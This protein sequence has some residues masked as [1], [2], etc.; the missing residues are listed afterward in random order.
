MRTI[1]H[2]DELAFDNA[3]KAARAASDANVPKRETE[4]LRQVL[5]I[6]I[7]G[8]L[9]IE[10]FPERQLSQAIENAS[11]PLVRWILDICLELSGAM[12]KL[13]PHDAIPWVEFVGDWL[14]LHN[15]NTDSWH[16][17]MRTN[18]AAAQGAINSQVGNNPTTRTKPEPH[19]PS[20]PRGQRTVQRLAE[21]MN[22]A[23]RL[24]KE[25]DT[26]AAIELINDELSML[27]LTA[28]MAAEIQALA[29]LLCREL[30]TPFPLEKR[31]C[32]QRAFMVMCQRSSH[33]AVMMSLRC[34]GHARDAEQRNLAWA[35]L[36][37]A[38]NNCMRPGA[39]VLSWQVVSHMGETELQFGN[40]PTAIALLKI[41]LRKFHELRQ[42]LHKRD[43][44]LAEL[45]PMAEMSV[46]RLV[47]LLIETGR[48]DEAEL[49]AQI[50]LAF[51]FSSVPAV[52]LTPQEDILH[53]LFSGEDF[54]EWQVAT[55]LSFEDRYGE[56]RAD[57]EFHDNSVSDA[58]SLTF[59]DRQGMLH[60]FVSDASR[61][62]LL[63]LHIST[64]DANHLTYRI[65]RAVIAGCS[66]SDPVLTEG[67]DKLLRS[68]VEIAEGNRIL[69]I[70]AS[71]GLR[72]MPW[73]ALHDGYRFLVERFALQR[74]TPAASKKRIAMAP[75]V[76]LV[77]FAA[78]I[79]MP[80][81]PSLGQYALDEARALASMAAHGF[82]MAD[83]EFNL[84]N[85]QGA[86]RAAN[87][88]H[89]ATHFVPDVANVENSRLLLGTGEQIS[90]D[91]IIATRSDNLN[92][93]I[94]SC[95]SS[96]VGGSDELFGIDET[97]ILAGADAVFST[98]WKA[99]NAAMAL[100]IPAFVN[101]LR[102]GLDKAEALA[103]AQRGMIDGS[104]GEGRFGLPCFF[105]S[106]VIA[107]DL[108]PWPLGAF[109]A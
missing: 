81:L 25:G 2:V 82:A 4:F 57:I 60:C 6:L 80:S 34:A 107:G 99:D 53:E 102:S 85:V 28:P 54:G 87:I 38:W 47:D 77:S 83:Q 103:R 98:L 59:L 69:R 67:F 63:N 37:Q 58:A 18:L 44:Q 64:E 91:Q 41:G 84:L 104:L 79:N 9:S 89:F 56:S 26:G 93:M 61:R 70:G 95:C 11:P 42:E 12:L 101:G 7:G 35:D 48:L 52:P 14:A 97:I 109:D 45:T 36:V 94:L 39:Q 17:R 51:D 74:L 1:D 68:A 73:A 27:D 50:K 33:E 86:M 23:R 49:V 22:H 62:S 88:V 71:R 55:I 105:A 75:K 16:Q 3:L 24:D 30:A 20:H 40:L 90:L 32:C 15:A 46:D 66:V 78:S 96:G 108:S 8:T 76:I 65:R 43:P 29:Q 10:Q 92:L 13:D 5:T 72:N 31:E 19:D 100:L 106:S 21:A